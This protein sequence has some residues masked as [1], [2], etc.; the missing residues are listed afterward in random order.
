MKKFGIIGYP[1][2]HSFSEKYFNKKF[3]DEN[4]NAVYENFPI[5]DINQF[6]ELI[7]SE[8]NLFGL[9]VTIPYKQ[10]VIKFLDEISHEAERVNAVN[11]I[12]IEREQKLILKGYNTDIYGF[13]K[14]VL[15]NISDI[16]ISALI[17]GTG[18]A[19]RAVN[20]GLENLNIKSKFVS[21]NKTNLENNILN[22]QDIT[23]NIF[24]ENLLIINA[25]PLGMLHDINSFPDIN[26]NLFTNKHIAFDLTYNP[27]KTAFLRKAEQ[28]GAKI[29]NGEE[30]LIFQAE[31][32]RE[33]LNI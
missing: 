16:N 4:I 18:G 5:S 8:N 30:M 21:R 3:S 6:P 26:Y 11:L 15:K 20:A 7:K 23:P 14:S 12:K 28:N 25:T 27:A 9:S 32:A 1:L 17:L 19:A 22:Y 33:I 31:K 2:E 24:L 10:Q 29:I 13:Q